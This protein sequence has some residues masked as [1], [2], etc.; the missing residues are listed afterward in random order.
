MEDKKVSVE[1]IKRALAGDF[2]QFAQEL[3]D[4]MNAAR[5]GRIIADTEEPVRDAN[6]EF[7]Q[8]AFQK[9]LRLL[10]AKQEAFSPWGQRSAEQGQAGDD[11]P[12]HQRKGRSS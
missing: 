8:R 1:E 5:A 9:A 11:T 3:A 6:A 12:N 7:R 4:A 10:Q 2:E